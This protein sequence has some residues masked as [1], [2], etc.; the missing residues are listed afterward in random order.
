VIWRVAALVAVI[1][2]TVAV[3][4]DAASRRRGD[5]PLEVYAAAGGAMLALAWTTVVS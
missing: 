3:L 1:A 2:L 5:R 4:W